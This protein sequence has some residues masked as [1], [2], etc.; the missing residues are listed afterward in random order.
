M[1][2]KNITKEEF[3]KAYN[4]YP[5]NWF[6]KIMFK[7]F[8]TTTTGEKL[9]VSKNVQ[10]VLIGLYFIGFFATVFKF[11]RWVI[12]TATIIFTICLLLLG[13]LIYNSGFINNYRIRKIRKELNVTKYQYF[14][15]VDKYYK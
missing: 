6:I 12:G 9:K 2:W 15:L 13:I 14:K 8:S 1:S 4:K 5:P 11:N 7:Y 10:W 3:Y